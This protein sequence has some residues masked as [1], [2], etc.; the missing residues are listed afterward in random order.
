MVFDLGE[1]A[2]TRAAFQCPRLRS[3]TIARVWASQSREPA[4]RF[5]NLLVELWVLPS[6]EL[7][8]AGHQSPQLLA[9]AFGMSL[10]CSEDYLVPLYWRRLA[11]VAENFVRSLALQSLLGL[12]ALVPS[13]SWYLVALQPDCIL[14]LW[15]APQHPLPPC[16]QGLDCLV[17]DWEALVML[18]RVLPSKLQPALQAF[19]DAFPQSAFAGLR[20]RG[21]LG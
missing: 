21:L 16:F 18:A 5:A 4:Q 20:L 3:S 14:V 2:L 7:L 10:S 9:S 1:E 15:A 6:S 11:P 12:G 8:V 13:A 17:R 19:L